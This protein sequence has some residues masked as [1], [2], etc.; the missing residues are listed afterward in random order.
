M[1]DGQGE[2]MREMERRDSCYIAVDLDDLDTLCT[3]AEWTVDELRKAQVEIERLKIELA[4]ARAQLARA[5]DGNTERE[6]ATK[7]PRHHA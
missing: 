6:D 4:E 5:V 2:V 1:S 7:P 3:S